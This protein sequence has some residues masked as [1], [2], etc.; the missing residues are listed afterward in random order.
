MST[1][2]FPAPTHPVSSYIY[3]LDAF[4]EL[5]PCAMLP[6]GSLVMTMTDYYD[7]PSSRAGL[8]RCVCE[9]QHSTSVHSYLKHYVEIEC[10]SNSA[11]VKSARDV[12]AAYCLLNSGITTVPTQTNPPGDMTYYI[13]DLPQFSR[14]KSC[15]KTAVE[16]EVMSLVYGLCPNNGPE[17]LA[18]CACIKE[19]VPEHVF[20]GLSWQVMDLCS[21]KGTN[22]LSYV[23]EL[24][25]LYCSAAKGQAT[26]EVDVET[27]ATQTD[28][29]DRSDDDYHDPLGPTKGVIVGAVLGSG[30][31]LLFLVTVIAFLT[32]ERRKAR[33][34]AMGV[35]RDVSLPDLRMPTSSPEN[36]NS[37]PELTRRPSTDG[38][39]ISPPDV[40]DDIAPPAYEEGDFGKRKS[41][42]SAGSSNKDI[43]VRHY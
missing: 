32:K 25:D 35:D 9:D 30:L 17:A 24:L 27:S 39:S 19:D 8:A 26:L 6:L 34:R 23:T 11:D 13:T 5:A 36:T 18:S 16:S 28:M 33:A 20:S 12:F 43:T 3:E 41:K 37:V 31:G 21:D 40:A 2:A 15:A 38:D 4:S 22:T 1:T 29:S 10:S 42:C 7:C 14:L